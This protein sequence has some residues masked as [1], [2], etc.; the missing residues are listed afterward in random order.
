MKVKVVSQLLWLSNVAHSF[1]LNIYCGDTSCYKVLGVK[2]MATNIELTEAFNKI[3]QKYNPEI[4]KDGN[5][6]MYQ[7]AL[8]AY[9]VLKDEEIR[10][11]YDIMIDD[12]YNIPQNYFFYFKHNVLPNVDIQRVVVLCIIII[13]VLQYCYK[14]HMYSNAVLM[15][16]KN[17]K[18][19]NQCLHKL[20]E[21]RI[22]QGNFKKL[23]YRE[24]EK[25]LRRMVENSLIGK[26]PMAQ[27]TDTL[28]I[29]ILYAPYYFFFFN[30]KPCTKWIQKQGFF[31]SEYEDMPKKSKFFGLDEDVSNENIKPPND[32]SDES[33]LRL[34]MWLNGKSDDDANDNGDSNNNEDGRKQSNE[35]NSILNAEKQT[36]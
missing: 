29:Q 4:N 3:E 11:D 16:M 19:R 30:F 28:F 27:V 12:P 35:E 36:N 8:E 21:E 5:E 15:E 26:I 10:R 7:K 24:E 31:S 18:N 2:K 1:L 6:M 33:R 22:K 20:Q 9:N 14:K 13:S 34:R 23:S 32:L 25:A 17:T